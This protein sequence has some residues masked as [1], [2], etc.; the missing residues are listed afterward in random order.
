MEVLYPTCCI[1]S[2]SML[3]ASSACAACHSAV[4]VP[5]GSTFVACCVSERSLGQGSLLGAGQYAPS[6]SSSR[7][8]TF[9]ADQYSPL[10]T[11]RIQ[12]CQARGGECKGQ[13]ARLT[14]I[15]PASLPHR[16]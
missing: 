8:S 10:P 15:R 2:A 5:T 3:N 11:S 13:T 16:L 12:R 7:V 6:C 1:C 9:T 4:P 14:E